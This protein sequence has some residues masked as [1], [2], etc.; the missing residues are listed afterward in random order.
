M[1]TD[2]NNLFKE[3]GSTT[4]LNYETKSEIELE[5]GQ[6]TEVH[7]KAKV[8]IATISKCEHQITLR[9]VQIDGPKE[10]EIMKQQLERHSTKFAQDNGRYESICFDDAEETW[11]VNLK[12]AILSTIQVSAREQ[13]EQ[14]IEK[15]VLGYCKTK[16]EQISSTTLQKTKFLSTCTKRSKSVSFIFRLLISLSC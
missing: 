4:T 16:Y 15:D 3:L 1:H 14:M 8:D 9:K 7:L 13:T 6:K 11:V 12:K 10:A 5:N 2:E